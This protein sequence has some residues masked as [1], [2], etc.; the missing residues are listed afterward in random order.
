MHIQ[1]GFDAPIFCFPAKTQETGRFHIPAEIK[2][3]L[4]WE[5]DC[6]F[7]TLREESVTKTFT[8]QRQEE[9]VDLGKGTL[10]AYESIHVIAFRP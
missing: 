3:A 9:P 8:L 7:S 10:A 6:L 4:V 5:G 1:P 2:D